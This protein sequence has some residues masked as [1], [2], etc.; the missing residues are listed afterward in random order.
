MHEKL[1]GFAI[2]A[3][4]QVIVVRVCLKIADFVL[5]QGG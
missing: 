3:L 5:V 1:D 2:I 4:I